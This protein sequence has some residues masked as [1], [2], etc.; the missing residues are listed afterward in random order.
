MY[1]KDTVQ[2]EVTMNFQKTSMKSTTLRVAHLSI[3]AGF[4]KSEKVDRKS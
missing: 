1:K 4:L 2:I 3:D